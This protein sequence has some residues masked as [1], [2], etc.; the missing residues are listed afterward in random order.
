MQESPQAFWSL[1]LRQTTQH[2]AEDAPG[3]APTPV[4]LFCSMAPSGD[5]KY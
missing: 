1:P 4:R 5:L 2:S 3:A